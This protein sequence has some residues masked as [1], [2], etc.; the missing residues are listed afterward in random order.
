M[1][2]N[3]IKKKEIKLPTMHILLELEQAY[4]DQLHTVLAHNNKNST[5]YLN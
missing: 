4:K 2:Y 3:K 1:Y 5:V